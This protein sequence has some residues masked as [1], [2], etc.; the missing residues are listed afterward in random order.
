MKIW[1]ILKLKIEQEKGSNLDLVYVKF[2]VLMENCYKY[3][4]CYIK[5]RMSVTER[6]CLMHPVEGIGIYV[7]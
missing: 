3:L 5:G 7:S 6:K 1:S 4:R 2:N